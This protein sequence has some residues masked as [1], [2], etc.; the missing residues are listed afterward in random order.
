MIIDTPI[1]AWLSDKGVG[2]WEVPSAWEYC[3]LSKIVCF[4][5]PPS[6]FLASL[7]P[8]GSKLQLK[9]FRLSRKPTLWDIVELARGKFFLGYKRV[10][11]VETRSNGSI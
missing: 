5:E 4:C 11:K 6:Y 2:L 1:K 9:N 10:F 8:Y 3:L 7:D